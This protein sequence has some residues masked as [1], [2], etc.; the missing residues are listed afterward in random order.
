MNLSLRPRYKQIIALV[1]FITITALLIHN[2]FKTWLAYSYAQGPQPEGLRLASGIEPK[3]PD[4]YFLIAFYLMEYDYQSSYETAM[5]EYKKALTLSPFNHNYWFYLAELLYSG[6]QHEQARYALNQ[7]TELSP[8]T[9]SLRWRSGM[10][11]SKLGDK[12]LVL[13]NLRAVIEH[14]RGRR[15]KAFALLW[16]AVGNED[17]IFDSISDNALSQY[18]Y[19]LRTTGRIEEV[20]RVYEKMEELNYDTSIAAYKYVADLIRSGDINTAKQIWVE[21]Y[22]DWDGVWNG[23]FDEDMKND[24]FDWRVGIVE[25]AKIKRDTD[26]LSGDYSMMINFEGANNMNFRDLSQVIPVRD[27]SNYTIRLFVKTD[28]IVTSEDLQWQVYCLYTDGLDARS[29]PIFGT[30]D[31]KP[32]T[33]SFTAPKGCGAI[34]L[35]LTQDKSNKINKIIT[36]TLWVDDVSM[37]RNN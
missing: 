16:Q 9:V 2:S 17:R 35:R 22:G 3:N 10:L 7:A 8:G 13:D 25:G 15:N 24:G 21:T 20:G 28:A 32:F 19:Y 26:S 23:S 33:I 12:E 11:A 29:D 1:V 27:G 14:D 37:E 5:D 6:G 31:W 30:H 4:Y 36:G 18:F 34:N